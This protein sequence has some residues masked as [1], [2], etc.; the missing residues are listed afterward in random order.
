MG[1][2]QRR[3]T[4]TTTSRAA[5][6][7]VL[8]ASDA[9][10][11]ILPIATC[12]CDPDGT[13]VQYNRRA[14]EVW[15]RKP[16]PGETHEHFTAV[17]RFF[18][19]SGEL[20][21]R[22][23][24]PMAEVLKTGLPV[25]GQEMMV[26]RPDSSRVVI[27]ITIDPLFDA[28]GALIGAISCF[29]DLTERERVRAALARTQ[30]DLLEQ[31]QRLAATYEHAAIGIVETDAEGKFLRVNEAICAITGRDRDELMRTTLS[32][33]TYADDIEGDLEAYRKQVTGDLNTY[34]IE[35]RITRGDGRRIW[36]SVRS[37]PVRDSDGRFLYGVRVVQD[38]T[39]RKA[40]EERQKLLIDE[41]NHRVKNTLATVQSLATQTS[42]GAP[43]PDKFRHAFEGRLIALSKAHDQLT[44]RHWE[45]ADLREILRAAI[46]PYVSAAA[47]QVVMR[48]EDLTLRPRAT[49]SLAMVFHEL[50]TNA[51]KYG[52]LSV[53]TGRIHVEWDV[54]P[55]AG[56][57][58]QLHVEWREEGGPPVIPPARRGFGSKFIKGSI[59]SELGGRAKLDFATAGLHCRIDIPLSAIEVATH[60]R[61][62]QTLVSGAEQ[63]RAPAA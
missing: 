57:D 10:L 30:S 55:S 21:A 26:E 44:A 46:A 45:S 35:K 5:L 17:S 29:Q 50:I 49:L 40:A 34:S 20:L 28:R 14:A 58:P 56:P 61:V 18:N 38:I 25:H 6:E 9:L 16:Q 3:Q 43:T 48:G 36:I 27:L 59:A 54:R 51:A 23:E 62:A 37:T 13:I 39:E 42:R 19:V 8:R 7:Q 15:G 12:I 63:R 31:E 53:P 32:Q 22:S 1:H 2:L 4:K 47:E 52:A 41:L 60:P 11:N 24:I 33:H